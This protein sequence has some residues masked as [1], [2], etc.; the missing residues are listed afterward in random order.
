MGGGRSWQREGIHTTSVSISYKR[1][2][3]E[4]TL[5]ITFNEN[6]VCLLPKSQAVEK[7]EHLL[8]KD[9][10]LR[11]RRCTVLLLTN[12]KGAQKLVLIY[13]LL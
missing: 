2:M 13:L 5:S 7:S 11:N 6:Y 9:R 8:P 4:N 3:K 12:F 1:K 10:E